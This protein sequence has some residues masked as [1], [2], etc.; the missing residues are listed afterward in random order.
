MLAERMWGRYSQNRNQQDAASLSS[1][2][3]TTCSDSP[4][5]PFLSSF[6]PS[7]GPGI[8]GKLAGAPIDR[9]CLSIVLCKYGFS[10]L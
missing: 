3:L 8:L 6:R 4:I 1:S 2:E 5:V 7:D 10:S 9:I